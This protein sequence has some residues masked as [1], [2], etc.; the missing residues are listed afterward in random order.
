MLVCSS[1]S[2]CIPTNTAEACS[3][4]KSRASLYTHV[5]LVDAMGSFSDEEDEEDEKRGF[6]PR[7]SFVLSHYK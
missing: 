4:L 7:C 1:L 2:A 3:M 6:G 5:G